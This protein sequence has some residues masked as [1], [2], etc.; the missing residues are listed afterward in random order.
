MLILLSTVSSKRILWCWETNSTVSCH[1]SDLGEGVLE[2]PLLCS[3]SITSIRIKVPFR[4][5]LNLRDYQ[6]S[7]HIGYPVS[8]RFRQ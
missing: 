8:V 3:L 5:L 2:P 4:A 7:R 1:E 6:A